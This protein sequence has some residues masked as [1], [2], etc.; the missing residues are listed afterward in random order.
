MGGGLVDLHQGAV[1]GRVDTRIAASRT[2]IPLLRHCIPAGRL[3]GAN[4]AR[5]ILRRQPPRAE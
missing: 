5:A 4:L 3:E 1:I 2:N